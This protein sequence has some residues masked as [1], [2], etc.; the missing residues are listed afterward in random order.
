MAHITSK[1]PKAPTILLAPLLM[2]SGGTLPQACCDKLSKMCTYETWHAHLLCICLQIWSRSL[3]I[4]LHHWSKKI[5]VS[6]ITWCDIKQG[7]PAH[8]LVPRNQASTR[9]LA[10]CQQTQ[11]TNSVESPAACLS[12]CRELALVSV[13][14]FA[15]Q[16]Q[17]R[18]QLQRQHTQGGSNA[19][20]ISKHKSPAPHSH[21]F[22]AVSRVSQ[23]L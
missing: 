10:C 7:E 16:Q 17:H 4:C 23:T 8:E 14:K 1:P 3:A 19:H 22:S 21:S 18:L 9:A 11:C 12:T 13:H 2:F 6:K 20:A 15:P 5:T